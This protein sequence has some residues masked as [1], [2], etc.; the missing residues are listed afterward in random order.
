[1]DGKLL[2]N[3]YQ[4]SQIILSGAAM[5]E[6]KALIAYLLKKKDADGKPLFNGHQINYVVKNYQKFEKSRFELI[7]KWSKKLKTSPTIILYFSI[8]TTVSKDILK[9]WLNKNVLNLSEEE[10]R[11][12]YSLLSNMEFNVNNLI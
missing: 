12:V 5:A 6:K 10:T 3:G 4:I 2:F 1:V 11:L 7:L 8:L 9:K